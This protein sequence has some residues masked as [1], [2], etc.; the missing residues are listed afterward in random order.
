[1]TPEFL[2]D[3]AAINVD[4]AVIVHVLSAQGGTACPQAVDLI[5]DTMPTLYST[6]SP[7]LA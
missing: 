5:P 3:I 7:G 1:M 4:E 6:D 2:N